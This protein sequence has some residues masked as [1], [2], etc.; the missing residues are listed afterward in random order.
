MLEG[1][2]LQGEVKG[3]EEDKGC[4]SVLEVRGVWTRGA[5]WV[6]WV[7]H[8][9][10]APR[11]PCRCGRDGAAPGERGVGGSAWPPASPACVRCLLASRK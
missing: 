7:P 6:L 5:L 8:G 3:G 10:C 9:V 2:M 11:R 4:A 1:Q